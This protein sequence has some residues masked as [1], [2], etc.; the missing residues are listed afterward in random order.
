MLAGAWILVLLP[1]MDALK[2]FK[3]ASNIPVPT[4]FNFRGGVRTL[5]ETFLSSMDVY[6]PLIFCIGVVLLFSKERGRRRGQ[7]DWTRRWGIICSYTAL[8]LSATVIL[9]LPAL[10]LAGNAAIFQSMP[11]KYQPEVT[12]FL[13]KL[14]TTYLRYGPYPKSVSL[15]VLVL[16]SSITMLLA[17]A[18]LFDAL[19]SSA[20]KRAAAIL[21]APL[22]FFSLMHL[23]QV[24]LYCSGISIAPSEVFRYRIYFW[25]QFIEELAARWRGGNQSGSD[26]SVFVEITKWCIVLAIAVWL[27]IARLMARRQDKK[28]SA[29]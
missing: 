25:P 16:C 11:L 8:L 19:R 24:G 17:C 7:L 26:L 13:V 1:L 10:V 21:L 15:I 5:D 9:F 20:S 22:V 14:S 2:T 18:A 28:T 6:P 3:W 23:G 4:V 29:A 27:T 12:P